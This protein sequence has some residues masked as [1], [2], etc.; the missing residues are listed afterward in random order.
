MS[1]HVSRMVVGSLAGLAATVPM[2]AFMK[3]AFRALPARER[4]PLPPRLITENVG[5]KAGVWDE[6]SE[7]ERKAATL[8]AHYGYGA[9]VGAVY[10]LLAP[11]L[12]LPP[13]LRGV[14]YG[15]GVWAVSYLGLLPG[16]RLFPPATEEP[17]GRN[18]LMIAA[19]LV[20]GW[21]LGAMAGTG[22]E[23][24]ETSADQP[25]AVTA[26]EGAV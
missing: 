16:M 6:L 3:A 25:S 4:Y 21:A 2:T 15:L 12:P 26:S 10:G 1:D 5:E 20:W 22:D 14:G 13:A 9:A 23:R 7:P 19:H 18:A 8:A 17:A 11:S 24:H